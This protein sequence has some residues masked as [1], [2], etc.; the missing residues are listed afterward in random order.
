MD[1]KWKTVVKLQQRHSSGRKRRNECTFFPNKSYCFR[2]EKN[3]ANGTWMKIAN[4]PSRCDTLLQFCTR[5][6]Q[7]T[8]LRIPS[9]PGVLCL[10]QRREPSALHTPHP[11]QPLWRT[12]LPGSRS[13]H[14]RVRVRL[15]TKEGLYCDTCL[16]NK[17]KRNLQIN[18]GRDKGRRGSVWRRYL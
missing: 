13:Y 2:P 5:K 1:R 7:N 12:L 10:T 17:H 18:N 15:W 11:Q 6:P 8:T 3:K 14:S 4:I 9:Q 16:R